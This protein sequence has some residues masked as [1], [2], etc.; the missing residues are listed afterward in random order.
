MPGGTTTHPRI[1]LDFFSSPTPS[2]NKEGGPEKDSVAGRGTAGTVPRTDR[3]GRAQPEA[4]AIWQVRLEPAGG[5]KGE[6]TPLV[7]GR[8][9]RKGGRGGG[10]SA[11]ALEGGNA[12]RVPP[13]S[14][15]TGQIA[16]DGRRTPSR[17]FLQAQKETKYKIPRKREKNLTKGGMGGDFLTAPGPY[18]ISCPR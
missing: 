13:P 18:V 2:L 7:A 3:T 12:K 11:G 4:K 6:D 14:H 8:S 1:R 10:G 15:A 9:P 5:S 16:A 17:E